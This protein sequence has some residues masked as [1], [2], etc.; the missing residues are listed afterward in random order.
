MNKRQK[1]KLIKIKNKKLT[2]RYPWLLPRSVWTDKIL[3]DYDYTYTEADCFPAGWRKSFFKEMHEEL[4][5]ELI[6]CDYIDEFRVFQIKEKWGMLAYYA[7]SIPQEC[8][9]YEIIHKYERLSETICIDC[10]KLDVP[11]IPING[12][13]S[14]ICECCYDKRIKKIDKWYT[15]H[16]FSP[17]K[18]KTYQELLSNVDYDYTTPNVIKTS[19]CIPG[20]DWETIEIDI[21]DTVNKLRTK[22]K[23]RK[24]L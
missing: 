15:D 19:H 7:G 11:N 16:G 18:Y 3:N 14:P 22:N 13:Y 4:R 5:E 21:S 24:D 9:V 2:N 6:R 23:K 8:N 20:E 12:W 17:Y 1:K 10:G